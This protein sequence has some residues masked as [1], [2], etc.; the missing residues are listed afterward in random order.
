MGIDYLQ[1]V[2]PQSF[3]DALDEAIDY[4]TK[5]RTDLQSFALIYTSIYNAC[6]GR[7][8]KS[9]TFER[10][11][12]INMLTQME[13][14]LSKAN[15]RDWSNREKSVF[16]SLTSYFRRHVFAIGMDESGENHVKEKFPHV[17]YVYAPCATSK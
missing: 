4:A 1:L 10:D 17:Q 13:E 15:C 2:M 8:R 14:H 9:L 16:C 3:E 6:T 11:D 5:S 12:R 7:Q